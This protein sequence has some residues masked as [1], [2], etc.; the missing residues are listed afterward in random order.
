MATIDGN[1][2]A[3]SGVTRRPVVA[4]AVIG[5]S[6]EAV[7][8]AWTNAEEVAAW[9]GVRAFIDLEVGGRFELLFAPDAPEGQRGSEGCQVLGYIPN[10]L[11]VISWNSPPT[12]PEIRDSLTQV[13]ISFTK[14]DAGTKVRL[15]HTGMGDTDLW[16]QNRAYFEPAWRSVLDALSRHFA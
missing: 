13:A 9:L 4:E 7:F 6:P 12:L 8:G 14:V 3:A 5:S 16:D 2:F 10:E 11:L 1:R 15:V